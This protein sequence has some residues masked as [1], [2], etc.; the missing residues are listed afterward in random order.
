MVSKAIAAN[1]LANLLIGA[2]SPD[3]DED[4]LK[5]VGE[6]LAADLDELRRSGRR[7]KGALLLRTWEIPWVAQELKR[8]RLTAGKTQKDAARVLS[9]AE[10]A[11]IRRETGAVKFKLHE[12]IP[13]TRFYGV[14]DQKLVT[15]LQQALRK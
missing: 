2:F 1:R 11:I 7:S 13:L 6:A 10:S 4:F 14:T 5:S 9:L 8:L 15:K 3:L 12:I